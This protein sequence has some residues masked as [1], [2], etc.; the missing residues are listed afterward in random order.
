VLGYA[1]RTKLLDQNVAAVV[2]NPEPKRRE[3]KTFATP[4]EVRLVAA[5]LASEYAPIPIL[6]AWTGLRPAEWLALERATSTGRTRL[7]RVRRVYTDGR[8]GCNGKQD[9]SLRSVPLPAIGAPGFEPG[10]SSPP[11]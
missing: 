6:A 3:V 1:V 5:E 10:T 4:D 2:P 8:V 9:S 7:L 11:D